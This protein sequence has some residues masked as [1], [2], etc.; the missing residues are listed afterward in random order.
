MSKKIHINLTQKFTDKVIIGIWCFNGLIFL[1]IREMNHESA[2]ENRFYE[3][4]R[5]R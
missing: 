3:K 4:V 2:L 1:K 5:N